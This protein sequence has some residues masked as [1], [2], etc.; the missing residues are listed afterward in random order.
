MK[1]VQTPADQTSLLH[2]HAQKERQ[3][4]ARFLQFSVVLV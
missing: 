3:V 1:R 4:K 2:V